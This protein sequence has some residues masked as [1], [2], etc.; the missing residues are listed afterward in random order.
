M[1]VMSKIEDPVE[2]LLA[3]CSL[4]GA[5]PLPN[6]TPAL[7]QTLLA[8]VRVLYRRAA[9]GAGAGDAVLASS[10]A[11]AL[12]RYDARQDQERCYRLWTPAIAETSRQIEQGNNSA[13]L[14]QVAMMLAD[15]DMLDPAEVPNIATY[16]SG[17]VD[18]LWRGGGFNARDAAG[19][20]TPIGTV[21]RWF[22]LP[23]MRD[24]F[25]LPTRE[26]VIDKADVEIVWPAPVDHGVPESV[27]AE[28]RETMAEAARWIAEISPAHLAWVDRL[29][30]GFA[31]TEMPEDSDL[32]SGSYRS[33]PG[34]VHISF[35]L[36]P[37]MV[38]ETLIHESSHQYFLLLN[39]VVP[40]VQP[41]STTEVFSPIKG[42]DRPVDRCTLA[43]HA[44]FNIWDFMRRG[45]SSRYGDEARQSME[46]MA[47]FTDVLGR[48]IQASGCLTDEGARFVGS[49]QSIFTAAEPARA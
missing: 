42:C 31:I 44:C 13:A 20:E 22:K 30:C 48:N 5:G 11:T 1:S 12:A 41:G 38:A 3:E 7:T 32:S 16:E 34:V 26:V 33:R 40:M 15:A 17:P 39:G 43:H 49:L 19:R 4:P 28:A 47:G 14:L 46:L 29:V 35:P 23:G 21:C 37:V 25:V 45:V 6:P 2:L 9:Q 10:I 24:K 8:L 18:R 27:I 36:D